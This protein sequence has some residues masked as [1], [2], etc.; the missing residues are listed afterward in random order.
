MSKSIFLSKEEF[1]KLLA[2]LPEFELEGEPQSGPS[3]PLDFD[4]IY[5][6]KHKV[7]FEYLS[8]NLHFFCLDDPQN[9]G[10]EVIET[11]LLEK[12][13]KLKTAS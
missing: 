6:G 11:E 7:H 4:L 10:D 2:S 8:D 12:L 13:N 1:E 9:P 3:F 5:Q